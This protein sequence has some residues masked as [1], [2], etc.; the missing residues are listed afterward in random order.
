MVNG[1]ENQNA[2]YSSVPSQGF[3]KDGLFDRKCSSTWTR[4]RTKAAQCLMPRNNPPL[5][6]VMRS[7]GLLP[8]VF[9]VSS[10][11]F[12]VILLFFCCLYLLIFILLFIGLVDVVQI[13][14]KTQAA[15]ECLP[16][17]S[18]SVNE[19]KTRRRVLRRTSGKQLQQQQQQQTFQSS[20]LDFLMIKVKRSRKRLEICMSLVPVRRTMCCGIAHHLLLGCCHL[21]R[22]YAITVI[23][24][25]SFSANSNSV[26]GLY[27]SK[28]SFLPVFVLLLYEPRCWIEGH[29]VDTSTIR[30]G[31]CSQPPMHCCMHIFLSRTAQMRITVR[32]SKCKQGYI[33]SWSFSCPSLHLFTLSTPFSWASSSTTTPSNHSSA[34]KLPFFLFFNHTCDLATMP[35]VIGIIICNGTNPPRRRKGDP[36]PK[37]GDSIPKEKT[38]NPLALAFIPK[39]L[40]PTPPSSANSSPSSTKA[41]VSVLPGYKSLKGNR[42]HLPHMGPCSYNVDAVWRPVSSMHHPSSQGVYNQGH[43]RQASYGSASSGMHG[44]YQGAY[45]AYQPTPAAAAATNESHMSFSRNIYREVMA[46]LNN[47]SPP[48][49]F[50]YQQAPFYCPPT[51]GQTC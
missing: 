6:T 5:I 33:F 7:G 21:Q 34:T 27:D 43:H 42:Y 14:V 20:T 47:P 32:C 9:L 36:L 17:C 23:L 26:F 4:N 38:L 45:T 31:Q 51:S 10:V 46:E 13:N 35:G 37:N 40:E 48:R 19:L 11:N 1:V 41:D 28:Q 50:V 29:N 39:G 22:V 30:S 24:K 44:F 12:P 18:D 2:F 8:G 49:H 25:S 3:S 16:T 15:T